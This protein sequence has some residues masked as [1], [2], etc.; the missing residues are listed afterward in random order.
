MVR[1]SSQIN[2]LNFR[3]AHQS[4]WN[5]VA[6]S[7]ENWDGLGGYYQRRLA[8]LYRF[9]IPEGHSVI[10]IGCGT[11][12]LL[13]SLNPSFG[14]GVDLA[15]NMIRRAHVL[16]SN[17]NF[18]T[19]DGLNLGI[20]CKFDFIILSDLC[21][22]VWD[23]QALFEQVKTLCHSRTRIIFNLHSNLWQLPLGIAQ[24]M[25][26][27]RPILA[28]NWLTPADIK[29]L[30]NLAGLE[31]IRSNSEILFPLY[32]PLI[33]SLA[34]RILVKLF[35]FRWAA[36]TNIFIGRLIPDPDEKVSKPL[37]SVIIPARNEMG[38]IPEIFETVPEMGGGTEL[39]FVEGHSKD[40]TYQKIQAE[41]ELNPNRKTQLHKQTGI[42]KG[43][44]VRLG[45]E[46]AKGEILMILDADLT[47][48]PA[49]LPRFYDALIAKKGE[50]VNGVRLVY[51]MET[52]AMRFLNLI[53]NKTFSLLFTWLL[54]QPIKDT[55]C[56]T[57]AIYKRDYDLIAENRK[58]FGDFDPFGDFDLLFGAAKQN[59]KIVEIPI[60][61]RQRTYGETNIQRWQHGW[62]LLKMV[63]FAARKIKFI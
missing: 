52:Q 39:V 63:L 62:M 31:M 45:F 14:V 20:H 21:N 37:V 9:N 55:L 41:I 29:N 46:V 1:D 34:N 33:S 26:L 8:E 56:G 3:R 47:V 7:L 50:F 40:D 53:G 48:P 38:N 57:K 32:L 12:D 30:L 60:R 19:A 15:E 23:V 24:K 17:L 54:D 58:F 28:Q 6:D 35:P 27:A 25:R 49:D 36:F 2:E 4:H 43:D 61:Y 42:G 13:N 51:P 18:L 11:G 22:D 5:K 44:A 16:H 10:E 59:L